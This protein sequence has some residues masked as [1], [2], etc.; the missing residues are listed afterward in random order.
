MRGPR[1]KWAGILKQEGEDITV[2]IRA[3]GA[4]DAVTGIPAVTRSTTRVIRAYISPPIARRIEATAG[5]STE[6]TRSLFTQG[7]IAFGDRF[8]YDGDTWE[9]YKKPV[10]VRRKGE[11]VVTMADIVRLEVT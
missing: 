9:V 3:T 8:P 5:P 2:S 10:N 1:A 6:E 7:I 11:T 4:A